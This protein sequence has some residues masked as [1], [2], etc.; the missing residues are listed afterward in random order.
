LSH[1]EPP[2][3]LTCQAACP[4][5]MPIITSDR[6]HDLQAERDLRNT[7]NDREDH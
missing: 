2:R 5:R 6:K 3:S 4:A 7:E 1:A